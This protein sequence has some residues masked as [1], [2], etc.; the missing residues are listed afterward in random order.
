MKQIAL[1]LVCHFLLHHFHFQ[2]HFELDFWAAL[3]CE[4]PERPFSSSGIKVARGVGCKLIGSNFKEGRRQ[5]KYE[6]PI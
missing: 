3:S 5:I 2:F 4:V 6:L 1:G